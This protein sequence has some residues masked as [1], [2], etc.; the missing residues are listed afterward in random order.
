[1]SPCILDLRVEQGALGTDWLFEENPFLLIGTMFVPPLMTSYTVHTPIAEAFDF[2]LLHRRDGGSEHAPVDAV[3]GAPEVRVC[4][5]G[6]R[7]Y[8]LAMGD[9]EHAVLL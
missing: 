8:T 7:R 1:M 9:F 4:R 2:L 5:R 6:E 3:G